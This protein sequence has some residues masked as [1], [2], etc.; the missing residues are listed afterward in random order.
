MSEIVLL[1]SGCVAVENDSGEEEVLR[2]DEGV[3]CFL[4]FGELDID[5][6]LRNILGCWFV[7]DV[8]LM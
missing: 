2:L 6:T 7:D 4:M 5:E 3:F 8:V 1:L